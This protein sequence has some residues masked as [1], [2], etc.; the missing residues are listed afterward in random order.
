MFYMLEIFPDK[1]PIIKAFYPN[2]LFKKNKNFSASIKRKKNNTNNIDISLNK[3]SIFYIENQFKEKNIEIT[4]LS[5]KFNNHSLIGNNN[6]IISNNEKNKNYPDSLIKSEF[7]DRNENIIGEGHF[8]KV[9]SAKYGNNEALIAIKEIKY[10]SKNT[11]SEIAI[12][13]RLKGLKGI[14]NFIDYAE[15]NGRKFI[16]Q[17]LCG[18]SLDKLYFLCGNKFTDATI[19]EIGIRVIKILKDIHSKGIIHRDIKPSNIFMGFL[20]EKIMN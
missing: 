16:I 10:L 15:K 4:T 20:M 17:N 18:P 9:F 12:L 13:K 19:L 2:Q 8:G 1:I 6:I 5:P 7:M 14:P 11:E 3:S